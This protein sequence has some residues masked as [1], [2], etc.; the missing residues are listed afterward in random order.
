V[1]TELIDKYQK[2]LEKKLEQVNLNKKVSEI[3][4]Y[5]DSREKLSEFNFQDYIEYFKKS[6]LSLGE[7][8]KLENNIKYIKTFMN[9]DGFMEY[10]KFIEIIKDKF[11]ILDNLVI[12][13]E[14]DKYQE[15]IDKLESLKKN[16]E[17]T[18]DYIEDIDFI[19][20]IFAYFNL[21]FSN[22]KDYMQEI[23]NHNKKV[24]TKKT[25]TPI[26]IIDEESEDIKETEEFEFLENIFKL[27]E[28][29]ELEKNLL[30][31]AYLANKEEFES[32]YNSIREIKELK[33]IF[34]NLENN[35]RL[36][37]VL[38]CL[39]NMNVINNVIGICNF[40]NIKVKKMLGNV[41]VSNDLKFDLKDYLV[42]DEFYS[43][44]TGSHEDFINNL[45]YINPGIDLSKIEPTYYIT[46]GNLTRNNHQILRE[47][48]FDITIDSIECLTVTDLENKLQ[49]IIESGL[50]S[51][52]KENPR[53]ILEIK[54][55][56]F[57]YRLK[58]A[59]DNKLEYKRKHL[60][61]ELFKYDGY[62]IT[63]E[64]FYEKVDVYKPDLFETT[65]FINLRN[66]EIDYNKPI[67][68][69]IGMLN[70]LYKDDE[71]LSY[72]IDGFIVSK[73]KVWKLFNKYLTSL[74]GV[75]DSNSLVIGFDY[76]ILSGLLLSEGEVVYLIDY[77]NKKLVDFFGSELSD[78]N[79]EEISD[80]IYN[81]LTS[82]RK[83]GG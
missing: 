17:N 44:F 70:Q 58:Y 74:N 46:N 54:D 7:M 33:Y 30:K 2:E 55:D 72:N 8:T 61:K 53:K 16:L 40:R 42:D 10:D 71:T 36:F 13:I 50:Y 75:M 1:I 20:Q 78:V 3:K 29:G 82:S 67:H 47:Y 79:L 73:E 52:F 80:R 37:V 49:K 24:L 81:G 83:M 43:L 77:L 35:K 68:P 31:D 56:A 12:D 51:Y 66:I 57:F 4:H 38:M 21:D 76:A 18:E 22:I 9:V 15:D 39:S 27:V 19:F 65:E 14:D 48:G 69:F 59:K 5:L 25:E 60:S 32:K 62:G 11:K 6:G 63:E 23:I 64:N 28:F 26:E 41:F 45:N 34:S